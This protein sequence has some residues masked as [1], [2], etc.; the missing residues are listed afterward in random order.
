MEGILDIFAIGTDRS[1]VQKHWNGTNSTSFYPPGVDYTE[2]A[3]DFYS[4]V[5]TM[6]S[7]STRVDLFGL[8]EARRLSQLIWING[9]EERAWT[10]IIGQ[11]TSTSWLFTP[12]IVVAT[13]SRG[14]VFVVDAKTLQVTQLTWTGNG[15]N[16]K[17]SQNIGGSCTSRPSAT[18]RSDGSID[19]FCRDANALLSWSSLPSLNATWTQWKPI[20]GSPILVHEPHAISR[21]SGSLQVFVLTANGSIALANFE[22]QEW[23]W[24]DLGGT[25]SGPPKAISVN[26]RDIDVF[27]YGIYGAWNH[28]SWKGRNG[29]A[30]TPFVP[31]GAWEDLGSP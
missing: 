9:W 16:P 28:L 21:S 18:S 2:Q 7:F 13:A 15:V 30:V 17:L 19:I 11:N 27:A 23:A 4:S 10:E 24:M 8:T 20:I 31:L 6:S 25:F 5:E 22:G 3:G 1:C 12:A 29:S 14:D 26:A